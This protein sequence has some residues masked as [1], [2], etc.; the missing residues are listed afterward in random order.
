MSMLPVL[1]PHVP[2]RKSVQAYIDQIDFNRRYTNHGPL[3]GQLREAF[4]ALFGRENE[5]CVALF[6][7]G[8]AALTAALR[9]FGL[10]PGSG[11]LIPSWT[12]VGTACAVVQAGLQPIFVDVDRST[13]MPSIE[14]LD[15]ARQIWDAKCAI[16]VAPFG[17]CVEYAELAV[18]SDATGMQILIDAAAAFDA[19]CKI[20]ETNDYRPL[21]IMVSLHATKLVTSIEGGVIIWDDA[22]KIRHMIEW[23]NFGIYDQND[24]S[25]IGCN[26]K[27]SEIHAAYGLC[28]LKIWH[29][30]RER[31]LA[32][33]DRYVSLFTERSNQIGF[34]PN[35]EQGL[36]SSTFNITIEGLPADA[37]QTL[38]GRGI[39]SRRWWRAGI[40][41]MD[42]Y[43]KMPSMALPNTGYLAQNCLGIP[44]SYDL[45]EVE[46]EL[47]VSEICA[48]M[49][50][51]TK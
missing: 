16:V 45:T 42:A 12:F 21:P 20:V 47:V 30:V 39:E 9:A 6:S 28:S 37:V 3:E 24:I 40:H 32:V 10:P 22:P 43:S 33:A 41:A 23:S 38:A 49:K 46:Q 44:F 1:M 5:E 7:S 48:M 27:M 26:A 2:D 29:D 11:C 19:A 4:A 15:R 13:W 34:A 14:E 17:A 25:T 51:G 18:F 31:M 36:A 35:V 8:T 50:V